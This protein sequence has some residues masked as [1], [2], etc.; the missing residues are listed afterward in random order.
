MRDHL[1]RLF[2]RRVERGWPVDPVL[3]RERDLVVQ[4]VDRA[5]G[6]VDHGEHLVHGLHGLQQGDETQQVAVHVS[7]RVLRG[8]PHPGLRREVENMGEGARP[9]HLCHEVAVRDVALNGVDPLFLQD[10]LPVP[11][12]LG[13][14]V[15][16]KV[17]QAEDPVPLPAQLAGG[18]E[19]HEPPRAGQEDHVLRGIGSPA[20]RSRPVEVEHALVGRRP[21]RSQRGRS[22]GSA[23]ARDRGPQQEH[24][25]R[26][27][28]HD[29]KE[30]LRRWARRWKGKGV[31]PRTPNDDS[32]KFSRLRDSP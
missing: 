28:E 20:R 11:L 30:E 13:G 10:V 24:Q 23:R 25:A 15:V 3:L 27:R 1:V 32:Q 5:R 31:S 17:V 29:E 12:Q 21:G 8:V 14:V 7:Q 2:G 22:R 19:P 4:A 26:D 6:G 16:V 9:Q 18:V